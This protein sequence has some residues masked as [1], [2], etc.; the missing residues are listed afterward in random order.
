MTL[1]IGILFTFFGAIAA[2]MVICFIAA[3]VI[4][5]RK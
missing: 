2:A 3:L 5:L 4:T 1:T